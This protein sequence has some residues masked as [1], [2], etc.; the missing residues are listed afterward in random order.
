MGG[1]CG[2]YENRSHT[3][4][5]RLRALHL[6]IYCREPGANSTHAHLQSEDKFDIEVKLHTNMYYPAMHVHSLA[7]KQLMHLARNSPMQCQL[8]ISI[9]KLSSSVM[10]ILWICGYSRRNV[11]RSRERVRD[12]YHGSPVGRSH[13]FSPL[14][15]AR[16]QGNLEVKLTVNASPPN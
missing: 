3:L 2:R 5:I 4:G 10:T 16:V 15:T 6:L 14:H 13:S 1:L 11:I 7:R 8:P 12:T 9:L